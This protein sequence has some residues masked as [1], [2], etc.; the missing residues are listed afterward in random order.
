LKPKISTDL[1]SRL[2]MTYIIEFLD[3]ALLICTSI[4]RQQVLLDMMCIA[5]CLL[6]FVNDLH[7][8]FE[9]AGIARYDMHCFMFT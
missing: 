3:S 6:D 4:L 5:L 9:T 7:I 1:S 2:I 8:I